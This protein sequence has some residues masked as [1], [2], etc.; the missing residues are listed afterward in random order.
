MN[1]NVM[2]FIAEGFEELEAITIIDLLRRVSVNVDIVSLESDLK[3]RSAHDVYVVCD[4]LFGDINNFD[5]DMIILP[6][7]ALGVANIKK[8]DGLSKVI[9]DFN[10][11]NKLVAA[12]CAAPTALG[13]LGIL[14]GKNATC[15]PGCESELTNADI[16]DERVVIDGNIITSKGPGTAIDFSLKLVEI[17][18]NKEISN[19]LKKD[20]L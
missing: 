7:G 6:G 12:I 5:V 19:E 10:N 4:K 20:L 16:V 9:K 14:E 8:H 2:I 17:L 3:V 18:L 15:Y 1:K 11:Q 13:Q